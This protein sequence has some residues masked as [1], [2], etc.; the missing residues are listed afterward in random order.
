MSLSYGTKVPSRADLTQAGAAAVAQHSHYYA[1]APGWVFRAELV[2]YS[3]VTLTEWGGEEYYTTAPTLELFAFPVRRFTPC[4]ATLKDIWSGAR[5]RFV[6]LRPAAKQWASRT[7]EEAVRQLLRRRRRQ[8]WVL[9]RKLDR[10]RADIQ[11][12]ESF[13][14]GRD[15]LGLQPMTAGLR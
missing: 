14:R 7:P 6:D 10:C 3:A 8:D 4:G 13:L 11:Q 12:C 1:D 9:S 15:E 5:E 2:R